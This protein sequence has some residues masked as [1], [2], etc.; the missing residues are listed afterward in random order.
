MFL[1]ENKEFATINRCK[2]LVERFWT[3]YQHLDGYDNHQYTKNIDTGLRITNIHLWP[4]QSSDLQ[5]N[6]Q[7][8]INNFS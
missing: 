8:H 6:V 4:G 1:T 5:K 7:A 3:H 2:Q